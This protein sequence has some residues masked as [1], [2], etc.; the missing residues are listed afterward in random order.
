MARPAARHPTDLELKILHILWTTGPANGRHVQ[1]ELA[2]LSRELAYT[3]VITV[4]NIMTR[5]R[6]LKRRKGEGGSFVYTAVVNEKA[7]A[8][9]MLRDLV[10]RV[11]HG[12]ASALL[13][14]LLEDKHLDRDELA[15]LREIVDGGETP[16]KEKRS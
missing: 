6:Y 1:A 16:A 2:K 7:N 4:L 5:K 14:K 12:S 15:K 13:L 11:F 3:S 9:R 10:D 8:G